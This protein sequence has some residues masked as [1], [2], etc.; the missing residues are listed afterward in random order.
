MDLIYS[1]IDAV[2]AAR[3]QLARRQFTP[4]VVM[5]PGGDAFGRASLPSKAVPYIT[6][7]PFSLAVPSSLQRVKPSEGMGSAPRLLTHSPPP[8]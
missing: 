6:Q 1:S 2:G 8:S 7:D 3:A 4:Q 5:L